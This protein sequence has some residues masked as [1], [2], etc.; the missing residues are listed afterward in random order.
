[1]P[2]YQYK[3]LNAKGKPVEGVF[4][5][6]SPRQLQAGLRKQGVFVT[7]YREKTASGEKAAVKGLEKQAAS[8]EVKVRAF[9]Q[10]VKMQEVA[11]I[12]RQLATLQRAGIPVVESLAAVGDQLEN[13][14][15]KEVVTSVR[16]DVKEGQSL[17]GALQKHPK[18]FTDIYCNMIKA[19]ESSGALD[20]VFE[21]LADFTESQVRLRNKIIGAVAYPVVMMVVGLGIVFMLM[22]FVIPK[23]TE[24]FTEMGATLPLMTRIMIGTSSFMRD[25]WY[26]V[27]GAVFGAV[28]GSKRYLATERGRAKF[29]AFKLSVPIFGRLM[30]LISVS[31]FARTLAT[32]MSSGVPLLTAMGIVRNV[33]NNVVLAKVIDAARDEIKEGATIAEPLERSKQFP[34]MMCHMVR[35]GEKTGQV[36]PM[37]KNVADAYDAQV[38]AKIATL[39]SILEPLMI[40]GMGLMVAFLV[41]SILMPML[42]MNEMVQ[43][44]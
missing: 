4:D 18:V 32:L 36:E 42:Q 33:M 1:M 20:L 12:T 34:P 10:R 15:L 40:V 6:E 43:G 13:P 38:E 44:K 41:F 26:L 23:I 8:R 14:R 17:S 28:W 22:M 7:E 9:F 24:M 30:R 25:F 29:D 21:R 31:R 5:S 35:I 3:G 27:F 19:G 2:L 37:L 39:T 11:E 16:Q